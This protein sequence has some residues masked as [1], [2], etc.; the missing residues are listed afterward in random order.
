MT[1]SLLVLRAPSANRVFT[2]SAGPLAVR[3]ARWVL[4]AHLGAPVDVRER[5][6]AGVDYLEI[7]TDPQDTTPGSS[8]DSL[9]PLVAQLSSAFA[10]FEASDSGAGTAPAGA[11][12][13]GAAPAGA[14]TT[15]PEPTGP[16][17]TG[18]EPNGSAL[19]L[20]RPTPLPEV[21][22]HGSELETT[23]RY[24]G[25]TN[26]QFTA[27]LL[28]L[29]AALSS[30]RGG[31]LRGDLALLDPTCGRGTTLS[32]ALRLGLSPTGADIDAKDIDAYRTFLTTWAKQ[33]HLPHTQSS[34][35]L[36]LRSPAGGRGAG[37][38]WDLELAAD[39]RAQRA[40]EVQKLH[41]LTCDTT[42]LA[43]VLPDRSVDALVADLPYGVQ[44]GARTEGWQRSP[45]DLLE[46]AMPA[47]RALLR[48]GGG[49]ALA[50]NRRT[51]PYERVREILGSHGLTVLSSDGAFRHRVDQAIDRDVV[52]AVPDDH[53]QLDLL[54]ALAASA[55]EP[56]TP[57]LT[58]PQAAA[59][60]ATPAR[61]PSSTTGDGTS[62]AAATDPEA[63]TTDP[64]ARAEAHEPRER[65]RH[66]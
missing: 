23:L 57:Q 31:V 7:R 50:L 65:T 60:R 62:A 61:A 10:V 46:Q 58:T 18:P 17:P 12:P 19:P 64:P 51:A 11:D 26:E 24:P 34:G 22:R 35:R 32:R 27:L 16:D 4:G 40:G 38:R 52:L 3:E 14:D 54:R 47:W 20:L 13:A 2:A 48:T 6:I 1:E 30:R 36:G 39:R 49:M 55:D 29:A 33:H 63:T 5:E 28:N 15:G 42:R 9:R 56:T 21:M 43:E 59:R 53:P 45:L 44:H 25:K 41:L 8:G 37:S 66:E